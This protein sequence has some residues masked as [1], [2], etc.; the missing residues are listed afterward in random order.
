M[1]RWLTGLN[2]E[3]RR[4]VETLDGPLLVLAGAGSGKTRV[5]THRI[6]HLL[7]QRA[8]PEQVLAVTFT[9]KAAAEMRERLRA[10]VGE[11]AAGVTMSTFHSLGLYML[12]E[13]ARR[14]RRSSRF[15]VYDA[16]DQQACLR[17]LAGRLRLGGSYDLGAVAARISAWKNAFVAPEAVEPGDDP[18]AQAAAALYPAYQEALEAFD[19]LDFDDLIVRPTRLLEHSDN[20]RQ[21]WAQ[22]FAWVLV[23]EYQDTNA[24]QLRLLR[25]IA[26]G[27]RNL[28]AVGDDDQSIYAWRGAQVRNILRFEADFSGCARVELMR[29][30]RSVGSVLRLANAVIAL[31]EQRHPKSMRAVRGDGPPA[32]LVIAENG[33]AEA[34]W[35]ADRIEE[36]LQAGRQR[37]GQIAVLYRSNSVARGFEAALR[38]RRIGYRVLGGKAFF[39]RKEVK[40]LTAYLRVCAFPADAISL[41]R[42]INTPARGIGPQTIGKLAGWADARGLPLAAAVERAEAVLDGADRALPAVQ[43][44]AALVRRYRARLRRGPALAETVRALVTELELK[45]ALLRSCSTGKAFEL[46]WGLVEGFIE[47]LAAYCARSQRP[48]LR[49]YLSQVALLELDRDADVRP[50]ERVTLSTLHG[51]KGA[52]WD[53]VYL[54]GLEEGLLPHERVL[55][56]QATDVEGSD[57]AEERR[58]CYVGITRARDELVLSRAARRRVRGKLRARA[59]S[60]FIAELPESVLGI[61][62]LTAPL[63]SDDARQRLAQIRAMLDS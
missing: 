17:E 43:A 59:P 45:D 48:R 54:V 4:A 41:R 7:E 46:R 15:A 9:N 47:G 20:C 8:A 40:D 52:E 36:R 37:P 10:M 51:A 27:H 38:A 21:R 22:R 5:I 39:D 13:E 2:P 30:Y 55:N 58:L 26:G 16:G 34:E 35:V 19:A 6:A 14:A 62:D 56:P 53:V 25:A 32:R 12:R 31:N 60:R 44:F 33:E 11:R 1:S 50:A 49:E 18:Y 57:L 42:V 24:A 63:S 23:D 3:Q 28:C 61:H 29:N